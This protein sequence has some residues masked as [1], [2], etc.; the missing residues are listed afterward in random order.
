MPDPHP[1]A[2]LIDRLY[3]ALDGADGEAMAAL[4]APDASFRDPAFGAL[5]GSE[6]GDMWRMLCSQST[7]LS[8]TATG[9][10]ADE[11]RGSAAW[12]ARYTFSATGRMVE[13]RVRASFRFADGLIADHHDEFSMWRWSRQA[14]GPQAFVL[15]SN[16]LGQALI[17]RGARARL[18]GWRARR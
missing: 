12:V 14:L 9:I 11:R 8:V 17:R 5:H 3:R 10:E 7:D 2:A 1:N 15:G 16:P 6:V 18:K 4:Y 13:N